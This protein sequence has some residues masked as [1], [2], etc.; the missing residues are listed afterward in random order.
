[1]AMK[2]LNPPNMATPRNSYSQVSIAGPGRLV[3]I[4]GQTAL[5][6]QSKVV[7]VGDIRAQ[8]R[9]V[10]EN[11]K[12]GVEA[13]GGT[14]SDVVSLLLFTTDIRYSREISEVRGEVFGAS[15]PPSTMVQVAALARPELLI[16]ITATAV[17]S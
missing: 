4:A 3:S 13:A 5:D 11:I 1:M 6:E 14:L 17:I 12:R 10:F 16:E 8:T 9:C 15:F 2:T 7:G